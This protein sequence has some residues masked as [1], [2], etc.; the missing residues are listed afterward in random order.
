MKLGPSAVRSDKYLA[1]SEASTLLTQHRHMAKETAGEK[2]AKKQNH[3]SPDGHNAGAMIS[4]AAA[5]DLLTAA[6]LQP[7]ASSLASPATAPQAVT[8]PIF[9]PFNAVTLQLP[10][11]PK[12]PDWSLSD[13]AVWTPLLALATIVSSQW[14]TWRQLR[15]QRKGTETQLIAGREALDKQLAEA[16]RN[17]DKQLVAARETADRQ[18]QNARDQAALGRA[19]ESRKALFSEFIDDFKN[20][21]AMIGDLPNRDF[22]SGAAVIEELAAMNATVNKIWLWAE[23]LTVYEV[24]VLQTELNELFFAA[25][26]ECRG[27]ARVMKKIKLVEKQVQKIEEER[28]AFAQQTRSFQHDLTPN[29]NPTRQSLEKIHSLST[30]FD[31]A[32]EGS[33]LGRQELSELHAK[34]TMLRSAY[35]QFLVVGQAPLMD[36]LTNLMG[37]ARKELQVMGDTTIL[38][39]QTNEIKLRVRAAIK[40]VQD[41]MEQ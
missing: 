5:Q 14:I 41:A 29:G 2:L 18:M 33:R 23:P 6:A 34:S 35:M 4:T 37:L 7:A 16:A 38:E 3:L 30:S 1:S 40:T 9:P 8:V 31:R 21:A 27:I 26:L 28:A 24:R 39:I 22:N 25:V 20:T 10:P 12:S 11:V 17:T 19:L 15:T 13:P 32:V 36:R